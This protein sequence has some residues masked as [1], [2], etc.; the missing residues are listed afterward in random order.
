[1]RFPSAQPETYKE[2]LNEI[3]SALS[4][5]FA[6]MNTCLNERDIILGYLGVKRSC[7]IH[8][9]TD[10][11]NT[12]CESHPL[13]SAQ[14]EQKKEKWVN[15]VCNQ[16]GSHAPYWPMAS[17]YYE[18]NFCPNCGADMRGEGKMTDKEKAIVMAYTGIAMLVGDKFDIFHQYIEEKMGRPIW[19][20]E[21]AS[22]EVWEEIKEA[23]KED[24]NR[25][26]RE[27][28]LE[29]IPVEWIKAKACRFDSPEAKDLVETLCFR[30]VLNTWREENETR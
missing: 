15:G 24:F 8:C 1:M 13:S 14:S 19:S 21:L 9:N 7:E 16:C 30:Y 26:C 28:S 4:E 11:K 17:T 20:H 2:E 27:T 3:A 29:A 5:K 23:T 18:S 6:Y 10:C 12:K 25:L 22:K